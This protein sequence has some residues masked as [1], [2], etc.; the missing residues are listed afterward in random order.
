MGDVEPGLESSPI[1]SS[2]SHKSLLADEYISLKT[3]VNVTRTWN[4]LAYYLKCRRAKI[5]TVEPVLF[6]YMFGLYLY[7]SSGEQY[8]FN[9]YGRAKFISLLNY[10]GPWNWCMSYDKLD[11]I[12]EGLGNKV[13]EETSNL[14]LITGVTGQ[15]PSIFAALLYGPLSDR[16]GRKPIML[17]IAAVSCITAS[18]ALVIVYFNLNLNW[19][20]LVSAVN[21][22]G[23]SFP[24]MITAVYSYIADVGSNKW[25]TLRLGILESMIFISGTLALS[26]VGVWLSSSNC[27][28]EPP[29][30]LFLG[31]NIAILIYVILL[32]PES[33]TP[34]ER[35]ERMKH[36]QS[37]FAMLIRGVKIFFIKQYSR[38]RLWVSL[39]VMAMVYLVAIGAS[40]VSTLFLLNKPLQWTPK[41]IGL[42][43]SLSELVN[44]LALWLLLPILVAI[45]LPD[46]LIILI[47][48][49][50][51]VVMFIAQGLVEHTWEMFVGMQPF[52]YGKLST[53]T[54][55]SVSASY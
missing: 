3:K 50:L 8:L 43:Q 18:L 31:S 5:V 13:E 48:G 22:L 9:R 46:A 44:G 2:E 37:G 32:L 24:G 35:R 12:T 20:I 38:W 47:G 26:L 7:L 28:F 54:A 39:F 29:L 34:A 19:L 53:H 55:F 1:S 6:L 41:L 21:A 17:V 23:G 4:P 51:A 15:F 30:W 49:I 33:L 45:R 52:V 16:I 36:H 27:W 11:N 42:F 14:N 25:L 40:N 10:T